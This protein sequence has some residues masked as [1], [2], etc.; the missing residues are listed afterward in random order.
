MGNNTQKSMTNSKGLIKKEK[1]LEK[2]RQY[3][4]KKGYKNNS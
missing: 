4:T 3:K 2:G 1:W